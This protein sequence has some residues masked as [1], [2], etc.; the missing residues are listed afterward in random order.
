[1]VRETGH[2]K[3]VPSRMNVNN[4]TIKTVPNIGRTYAT[5]IIYNNKNTHSDIVKDYG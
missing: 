4:Y 2:L 5:I 1:M 3:C